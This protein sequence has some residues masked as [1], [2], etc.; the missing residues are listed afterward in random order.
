MDCKGRGSYYLRI[1]VYIVNY[2]YIYANCLFELR[3]L[4]MKSMYENQYIY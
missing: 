2:I 1:T 3:W 4:D